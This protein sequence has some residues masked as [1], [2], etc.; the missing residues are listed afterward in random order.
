M[1]GKQIKK[2]LY[3]FENIIVMTKKD[4]ELIAKSIKGSVKDLIMGY[5]DETFN[6]IVYGLSEAL[7]SKNPRFD[8]EKFLRA[9]GCDIENICEYCDNRKLCDICGNTKEF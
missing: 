6:N 8:K 1:G 7:G 2:G 5:D 3:F 4:Y 9:C